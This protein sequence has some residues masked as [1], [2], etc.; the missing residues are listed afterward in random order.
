MRWPTAA[1]GK[2]AGTA[3][4]ASLPVAAGKLAPRPALVPAPLNLL[5]GPLLVG[6]L[7]LATWSISVMRAAGTTLRLDEAP[8][9]VVTSGPFRASRNPLYLGAL[10]AVLGECMLVGSLASFLF[11][12][13]YFVGLD[14]IVVPRE[15]AA[16][17]HRFG[18][19]Y[20]EYCSRVRR[21]L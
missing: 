10:V 21:W 11:P 12:V 14:R 9:S 1:L 6:G 20:R 19:T 3:L 17:A 16:L 5:G 15:E 7:A 4:L 2:I 8:A 18:D 13:A